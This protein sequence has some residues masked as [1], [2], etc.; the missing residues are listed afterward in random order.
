MNPRIKAGW[1]YFWNLKPSEVN[2]MTNM[3][4][5]THFHTWMKLVE[6]EFKRPPEE[7]DLETMVRE[8]FK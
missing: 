5:I 3:A 2:K 4:L 7:K 1:N 6:E 8:I